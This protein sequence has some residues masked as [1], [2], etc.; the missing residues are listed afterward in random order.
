MNNALNCEPR[1]WCA[2][3]G[4]EFDRQSFD[5]VERATVNDACQEV[6]STDLGEAC[7][8]MDVNSTGMPRLLKGFGVSQ[9][10]AGGSQFEL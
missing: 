10:V 2:P 9:C 6:A 5:D 7:T 4:V 1:F 8:A 3:E